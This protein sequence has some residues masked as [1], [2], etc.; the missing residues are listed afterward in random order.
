MGIFLRES[1][2]DAVLR[3]PRRHRYDLYNMIEDA[4]QKQSSKMTMEED[5]SVWKSTTDTFK[6]KF[7]TSNTWLLL[8]NPAP[9]V[10]WHASIWF[11]HATPKYA[12]MAWL[13]VLNRLIT[14]DRMLLWNVGVNVSCILC[15]QHLESRDHLFF[16]CSYSQEV[17]SGLVERLLSSRYNDQWQAASCR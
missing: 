2:A 5:I 15:N 11:P 6:S 7:S 3:R 8:R 9:I 10:S 16:S 12:F 14:G 17:W 13:A 1:V 4:I